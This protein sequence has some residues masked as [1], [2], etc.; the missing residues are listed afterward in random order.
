MHVYGELLFA[1]LHNLGAD[2]SAGKIG[3]IYWNT[4]STKVMLDDGTNIY[5]ML[6]NDG[7]AIIGNNGTA[8]SNVRFHRGA[9]G[10]LQ[11]VLGG[12]ATAEGTLS[13]SLAQISAKLEN[14]ITGSLPAAA[15]AGRLA[16]DTT[17]TSPKFDTGAAW[18][19]LSPLTTRGDLYVRGASDN[20]RLAIGTAN[21]VLF[22]DGTD[23]AWGLIVNA[24][25]DAAAAIART[26]LASGTLNHVLINDGS[27]VMSSEAALAI[28]RGG[29]GQAT[30]AAAFDALSPMTTLGD[31]I[32]G[33][34]SGTG[35]RLGIGSSGQVLKQVGGLPTW[36]TFSGGINYIS[37]NPDAEAD[38]TGWATYADAAA[39]TPADG[40]G[41]SPNV[42]WTRTTSS[43]LRGSASFLFTKDAVNRQGQGVSFA[44]T[45][46]SADQGKE[47]QISF[48]YAIPSGTFSG[49][50]SSSTDSDLIVYIYDVTNAVLI[51][52]VGYK[53]GG[54]VS[55]INYNYKGSFQTPSNSTSYRLILHC[56]T[57][58]ASAYTVKADNFLVGPQAVS[59]TSP[60]SD[61]TSMS[62]V[63]G[64]STSAPTY[65]A[66][67]TSHYFYR[68]VGDSL[69][70]DVMVNQAAVGSAGTGVYIIPLP[71]GLSI[72]TNK[73]SV[74]TNE[75]GN[76]A[77]VLGSCRVDNTQTNG[78]NSGVN[79]NV[80]GYNTTNLTL[81]LSNTAAGQLLQWS[82]TAFSFTS[83]PLSMS[84]R[85][86]VPISG[87]SSSAAVSASDSSEGRVVAARYRTATAQSFAAAGAW[88]VF[89]ADTLVHDT[90][91]AVT[92]GAAWKF[93]APCPGKYEINAA[94]L[95]DTVAWTVGPQRQMA[96]YKNGVTWAIMKRDTFHAAIT[97]YAPLQGTATIDLVAGDYIQI[98]I[99]N[100]RAGGACTLLADASYNSIDIFRIPGNQSLTA[101]ES[102]NC[103]YSTTAG[104]SIAATGTAAIV[105]FGTKAYDSHG[106]VTTGASWKFTAPTSGK[107]TVEAGMAYDSALAWAAGN[108]FSFQ[109]YKN[110]SQ[111]SNLHY[112][113]VQAGTTTL[114]TMV[115]SVD[116][117]LLAGDY[118]D[119]RAA[120]TRTAGAAAMLANGA[121]NFV[122]VHRSGN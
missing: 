119:I 65:G 52:P 73:A 14:Y 82:S 77:S 54:A 21:K 107:Y 3:R 26:K 44:F 5:A 59:Y 102:V 116:I 37:S 31:I 84:A 76:S 109:V 42:T 106:A 72:D 43:P 51:Q 63:I 25:I 9:A 121:Y 62:L 71:S 18:I 4:V 29:T 23:P 112:E 98:A 53:L 66:G 7:K 101:A 48:D 16:M 81:V 87:W 33:G 99:Q 93:T 45:I 32:Y 115:G 2:P 108:N 117:D 88:T 58:S 85:A 103:R 35:T 118:I 46:D 122:C 111:H 10:V 38:T 34:A 104:Q 24:Y 96:L 8:N 19:T 20:S 6:R 89:N 56:A 60:M 113:N 91:A 27:G 47:L 50:S 105:D 86:V 30:K 110:G 83:N 12:D 64:A 41:G 67:A 68:R 11:L 74:T 28:S 70:I 13:T 94:I 120:N 22:S 90:H 39:A 17:V 49:G 40:T 97:E 80:Y 100:A 61:W 1:D 95:W 92:T 69:E 75:N 55:G 78:A 36:A 114:Y 57:T 15:N 79:G